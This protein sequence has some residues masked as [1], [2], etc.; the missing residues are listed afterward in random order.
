MKSKK[1]S[2]NLLSLFKKQGFKVKN[3]ENIIESKII[4]ERSGEIFKKSLL[5]FED[6]EGK[7]FSLRPDL[8]IS[9][10]L[11]YI[12]NIKRG[13]YK[14]TYFDQAYRRTFSK[15]SLVRNQLGCEI[16]GS[17]SKISDIKIINLIDSSLRKVTKRKTTIKINDLNIFY[18]LVDS[19]KLPARWKLRLKRHFWRPDYFNELL[20]RLETDSDLKNNVFELDKKSYLKM[21]RLK[22]NSKVA[23][24]KISEI[25]KRFEKKIKEPRSKING[26]EISRIL[27]EYLK[28][29]CSLKNARKTLKNFEFKNKLDLKLNNIEVLNLNLKNLN[30]MFSSNIGRNAEYYSGFVFEIY[31]KEKNIN[32]ASGGR[33]DDLMQILGAK[34]K[35]PAIGGAINYDNLLKI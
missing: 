22:K 31:T 10:C 1:Y 35:I 34:R 7:S 16:I 15:E 27:K 6:D 13:I 18:A 8:T 11:D 25:L 26:K 14:Y 5:S 17:N 23:G 3:F 28:I 4:I 29:N 2:E 9:A 20:L 19:L 24:R 30:S 33:Y 21:K 32:L 12:K